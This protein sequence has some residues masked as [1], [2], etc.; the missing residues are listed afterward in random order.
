MKK[1]IIIIGG[2]A[3]GLMCA[4]SAAENC[5]VI[6]LE[7]N[8]KVAKKVMITGK[9]RCN[10]TNNCDVDALISAAVSNG[11]FLYSAFSAFNSQD[12]MDFF[13]YSGVSLKTERGNR[14]F[15]VSDKAADIA[16][17]LKRRATESGCEI[18]T[19]SS[20]KDVILKDSSAVGV[21]LENGEKIYADAVVIATGGVSYPLTGSTGDG[22]RFAK[23]AGHT[24]VTPIPSLVPF[25]VYEQDICS[26][27]SGLSLKN[28]RL[29]V[30]DTAKN[31]KLFS[32]LGE[33][34]FTH[35]G[36]SGPLV[37]SA[38]AH[39]R[40]MERGRYG[41]VI[42]LKPAIDFDTLDRRLLRDFGDNINRDFVNSLSD[43]LPKSIIPVIIEMSGIPPRLKVN[44]VTKEQRK[45]LCEIIKGMKLSIKGFR[46]IEEAIVTAGGVKVSEVDPRTMMSK[47][48]KSLYFVGE[49]LDIDSYTGGFNLQNAFSTGYLAGK[50]IKAG[51]DL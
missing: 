22:Y 51:D 39:T 5:N 33:M 10:V 26:S 44:S 29:T 25:T 47:K 27:L 45:A 12:T 7:K 36:I 3:S 20:V 34:L 11:R 21:V 8:D 40:P 46:P 9:G 18:R 4:I 42:D 30:Y 48:I 38:S 6:V 41:A 49:V 15:P 19:K 28:V 23:K 50:S 1:N 31:K 16:N 17:A 32:E 43:L 14:V 13:E 2:G 24:V 37:L 35:T